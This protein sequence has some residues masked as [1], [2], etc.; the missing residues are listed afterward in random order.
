MSAV[1]EAY[2]RTSQYDGEQKVEVLMQKG[3]HYV[4]R[5]HVAAVESRKRLLAF[6]SPID[7][8]NPQF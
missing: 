5:Q 7:F 2:K 1:L 6:E 3:K 8:K 4:T